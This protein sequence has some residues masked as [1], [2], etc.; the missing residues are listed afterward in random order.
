MPGMRASIRLRARLRLLRA[1]KR[2][3]LVNAV[4]AMLA[5][6]T[7]ELG[8]RESVARMLVGLE[9]DL[10]ILGDRVITSIGHRHQSSLLADG[11]KS[12][13]VVPNGASGRF[14]GRFRWIKKY[15][16]LGPN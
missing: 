8:H 12:R 6:R 9:H 14:T 5:K 7:P 10:L 13:R 2:R 1:G 16:Y 11:G 4:R 15:H 3:T